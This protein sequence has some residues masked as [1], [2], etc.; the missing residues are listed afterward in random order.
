M[1]TYLLTKIRD[2]QITAWAATAAIEAFTPKRIAPS[3]VR[4]QR[5]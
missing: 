5:F 4:P 1:Q 3:P 2:G